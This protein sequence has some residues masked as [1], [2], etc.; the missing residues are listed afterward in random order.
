MSICC[1]VYFAYPASSQGAPVRHHTRSSSASPTQAVPVTSSLCAERGVA[2]Q[3]TEASPELRRQ[4]H[5]GS[6]SLCSSLPL[7]A[8][9][10]KGFEASLVHHLNKKTASQLSPLASRKGP[11]SFAR[12]RGHRKSNSLGSKYA[13]M[14]IAHGYAN[15]WADVLL[16]VR[17]TYA[18]CSGTQSTGNLEG[19]PRTQ[20]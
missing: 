16:M 6:V 3:I 20:T 7:R 18:F 9:E 5:Q 14:H 10:G 1:K 13:C 2:V 8:E 12:R 4:G 15:W 17:H 11:L 19:K